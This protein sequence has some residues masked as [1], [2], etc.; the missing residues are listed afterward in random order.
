METRSDRLASKGQGSRGGGAE[1]S[2][3]L[4]RNKNTKTW[5]KI[6]GL[7]APFGGGPLRIDIA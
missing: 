5:S 2:R 6:Q 1:G 7:N 4:T 3:T